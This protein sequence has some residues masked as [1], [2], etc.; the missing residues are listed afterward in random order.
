M[1]AEV[2]DLKAGIHQEARF[3]TQLYNRNK[4]YSCELNNLGSQYN[5]IVAGA[6]HLQSSVSCDQKNQWMD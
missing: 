5:H 6:G 2:A 4:N 3:N 1:S